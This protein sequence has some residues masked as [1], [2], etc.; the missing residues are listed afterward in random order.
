MKTPPIKYES[1]TT[2][3]RYTTLLLALLGAIGA[4][5][6]FRLSRSFYSQSMTMSHAKLPYA[7]RPTLPNAFAHDPPNLTNEAIAKAGTDLH[8]YLEKRTREDD[9]DSLMIAVGTSA[10]PLWWKGYGAARANESLAGPPPDMDTI[11]RLASIS[12]MFVVLE[13]LILRDRG[14]LNWYQFM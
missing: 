5:E 11:Y 6:T 1:S 14:M 3:S 8:K 2:R 13:T 12:K 7:C 9:I 10:G 4:F